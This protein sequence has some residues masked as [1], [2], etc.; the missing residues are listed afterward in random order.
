MKSKFSE[1]SYNILKNKT[2]FLTGATGTFGSYFLKKLLTKTK[3]KKII[4]FSRDELKQFNLMQDPIVKKHQNRVRFFI[5]DVRDEKRLDLSMHNNNV[6]ILIHCAALKQVPAVEYNPFEAIQTNILGAQN[7]ILSAQKNKVKKV[8]AL[9]TDKA[10]SPHNLYGATKLVSDKIFINSNLYSK[11]T[12][13]SVVRYGNVLNS[14]GSIIPFYSELVKKNLPLPVTD[15]KMTRFSIS[16]D[17]AV[18][19]VILSLHLMRGGETFVP[20]IPSYNIMNLIK[21]FKKNNNF[22]ITGIRPGEKIN[23]D[24][25]SVHDSRQTYETKDHFIILPEDKSFEI[26]LKDYLG[27][28]PYYKKVK[29]NFYYSSGSNNHFYTQKE[30]DLIVEKEIKNY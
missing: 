11:Y 5:G 28:K 10:S 16:I 27:K 21:S 12:I 22:K 8:I 23:E 15:K 18:N 13:S 29:K 7:V 19:F 30:L 26:N 17:E 4:C 1:Y 14:R 25:I 2:I 6:D 9:S 20:K 3:I 24:L